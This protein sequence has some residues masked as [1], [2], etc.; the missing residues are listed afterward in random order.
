MGRC[1][2]RILKKYINT[3][4]TKKYNIII[5]GGKK[6]MEKNNKILAC[7]IGVIIITLII[8]GI[9]MMNPNKNPQNNTS[10]KTDKVDFSFSGAGLSIAPDMEKGLL[11]NQTVAKYYDMEDGTTTVSVYKYSED[12]W[13]ECASDGN[14]FKTITKNGNKYIVEGVGKKSVEDVDKFVEQNK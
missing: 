6:I 10:N 14:Y 13:N 8:A 4:H 5:F 11:D 3:I 9:G 2:E 7:C 1:N 12:L